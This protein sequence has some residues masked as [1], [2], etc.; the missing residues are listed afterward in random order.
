MKSDLFKRLFDIFF[1]LLILVFLSPLFLFLICLIKSFSKGPVFY[2]SGRI[3]KGF[4][5]IECYKF[6]TMY[7]DADQRLQDL[8]TQ[9]AHLLKEWQSFQ[10]LKNDPRIYPFGKFLR[11]TSLDELP[12]FLNVLLGDLSVVGPRP[13]YN[14]QVSEYLKEKA[15]K[16]LSVKPGITGIWQTSGRNLLTMDERLKLEEEYIDRRSFSFDLWIIIKTIP[17]MIFPKG[18]F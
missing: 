14:H 5:N 7:V 4:K 10:K 18:A 1:S 2:K 13:F 8:L 17:E 16:I 6:R 3:G 11:K 12:Q 9:N 15:E